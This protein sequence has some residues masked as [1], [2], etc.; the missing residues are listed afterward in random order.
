MRVS[1]RTFLK[2]GV[3]S[4]CVL[5]T[6]RTLDREVFAV[7]DT[8]PD[9]RGSLDL[10]KI[11]NKDAACIAALAAAVLKDALPEDSA[12][13]RIAIN[14]VVEAFDRTVAGL[15]PAVQKEIEELLSLLTFGL[16]RRYVAGVAK[17]WNE[18]TAQDVSYFL[19][20]WRQSRFALLQQGY[21]ALAR[22]IMACWYGN[23][24]SWGKIGYS[25]PPFGK[26]L[27]LL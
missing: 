11:S 15:S 22:V 6:A 27:G 17:P 9:T 19:S 7:S 16:S 14:E 5:I 1:R 18:V 12:S 20:D 4:A 26:E 2:V 10:K 3:V 24:L 8:Q 23:P 25:G 13:Q 21:Q